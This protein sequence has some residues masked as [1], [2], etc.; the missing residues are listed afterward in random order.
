MPTKKQRQR[1][2]LA[3]TL[4]TI[5]PGNSSSAELRRIN[6]RVELRKGKTAVVPKGRK[7]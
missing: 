5:A 7:R 6:R 4:D 1:E 2:Q 3:R